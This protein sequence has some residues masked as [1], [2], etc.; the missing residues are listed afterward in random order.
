MQEH[1]SIADLLTTSSIWHRQSLECIRER[2][3][4][5]ITRRWMRQDKWRAMQK[6]WTAATTISSRR[7]LQRQHLCAS[8]YKHAGHARLD[9]FALMISTA[10]V[11]F[12]NS[13]PVAGY[14]WETQ[15]LSLSYDCPYL[16]L[17]S[18]LPSGP[19]EMKIKRQQGSKYGHI[20][21][22]SNQVN[23]QCQLTRRCIST[24][25]LY[26]RITEIYR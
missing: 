25:Y 5:I 10:S 13:L 17:P 6:P 2:T 18:W 16:T 8:L 11:S 7:R 21:A 1:K 22:W 9:M 19:W 12:C 14:I 3:R 20:C 24:F 15:R 4:T 26:V 23:H